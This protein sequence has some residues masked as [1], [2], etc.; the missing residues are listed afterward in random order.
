MRKNMRRILSILLILSMLIPSL[1]IADNSIFIDYIQKENNALVS[2]TGP[3]NQAIS[4]TIKD[5]SRYYYIDQ[6]IL[7]NSGK[8]EFEVIL[9]LDKTYDCQVNING[10]ISTKK[11]VMKKSEVDPDPKPPEKVNLYIKG[12][13][14]TILDKKG[15]IINNNESLLSLTTRILD[16]YNI[17]YEN[18]NGYITSIDN[19]RELDRGKDSGWMF[20]I[21]GVYPNVGAGLVRLKDGDSV[22]WL[23]TENLG[24]DIG[25]PIFSGDSSSSSNNLRKAIDEALTIVNKNSSESQIIKSLDNIVNKLDE[26]IVPSKTG[27]TKEILREAAKVSAIL[28]IASNKDNS[29]ELSIKI[30]D[31]AIKITRLLND[32]VK[33]GADKD[34]IGDLSKISGENIGIALKSISGIKD[35]DK[36]NKIIENIISISV[37]VEDKFATIDHNIDKNME[38]SI[39]INL[40]EDNNTGSIILPQLLL[41]QVNKKIDS[42]K[43]IFLDSMIEIQANNLYKEIKDDLKIK[44][45]HNKDFTLISFEEKGKELRELGNPIK[46]TLTY[47]SNI[48]NKDHMTVV[49]IME[50]GSREIIGG[51]YNEST[52]SISFLTHK[53]GKFIIEENKV[54]FKDLSHYNWAI[55]SINAMAG[56]GIINGKTVNEF[57]PGDHIT[58]AEFSALVSRI[59]KYNEGSNEEIP[60]E[61]VPKDQWYYESILAAYMNGLL[62]GKSSAEFDPEGYITREE[63]SRIAGQIL[64]KNKYKKQKLTELE[65]FSDDNHIASWARV[66]AATIVYHEIIKGDDNGRFNPKDNATRAETAVILYRLY[67]LILY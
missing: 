31:T 43:L 40:I 12:Y 38:R 10:I 56:K 66:E 34:I 16:E 35:N 51:V 52:K 33:E 9:G 6:G 22:R 23:Y 13:K 2:V 41:E 32:L 58:R 26:L 59:L 19:Q 27:D 17:E 42:I 64:F 20:S 55:E 67:E 1:A 49:L 7:D 8:I 48:G 4:I 5:E 54:E 46:V 25:A 65:I 24:E 30:S 60:F 45:E 14:G 47:D 28:L 61:D 63:M 44:L 57:C 36:I 3:K 21:N 37:K 15:I 50:D 11:I 18:R 29:E 62:N 53:L 39:R